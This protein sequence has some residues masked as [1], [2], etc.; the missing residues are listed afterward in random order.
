MTGKVAVVTGGSEGIGFGVTHTLLSRN[1]SK[2]FILSVSKDVVDGAAEAVSKEM[3]DD[4]AKRITWLQ[5]DLGDW[6]QV[7]DVAEKIKDATDRL[8]I[9]VNNAGRGIMTYQLTDYGVDRHMAVNH[10]GHVILT[11]HLL[12]LMK[13]TAESGHVVRI[14]NQASN[15]HDSAPKDTRFERLDELNRDIGPNPQYGRSKLAAILYAR[16]FNRKV[17]QNG[18]PNVLMNATHPGI[19]ST[20]MSTEDIHEP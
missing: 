17:T 13:T 6:K 3:G 4:T 11:S 19:V 12:P 1:I 18:H 7:K 10:M 9:V 15:L 2:L 14:V 5:C 20:K 8:D 16:Y